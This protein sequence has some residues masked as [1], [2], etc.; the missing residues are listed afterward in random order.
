MSFER[1]PNNKNHN[2]Y[3]REHERSQELVDLEWKI[4]TRYAEL[5][6][7]PREQFAEF[8]NASGNAI[9]HIVDQDHDFAQEVA[10]I[11][12]PD[13]DKFQKLLQKYEG[14]V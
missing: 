1:I 4:G 8:L 12:N 10:S 7:I 9:R 6:G 14:F 13:R 2:D 3:S 11:E 5:A